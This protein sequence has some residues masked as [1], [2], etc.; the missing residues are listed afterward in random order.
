MLA[1]GDES[2]PPL[3]VRMADP[4]SKYVKALALFRKRILYVNIAKDF[5]VPFSTAAML[6]YN[7]YQCGE[8]DLKA[9]PDYP[10]VV[11]EIDPTEAHTEGKSDSEEEDEEKEEREK[12]KEEKEENEE[13]KEEGLKIDLQTAEVHMGRGKLMSSLAQGHV[14]DQWYG[15]DEKGPFLKQML[16]GLNSIAWYIFLFFRCYCV[17][18]IV[19]LTNCLSSFK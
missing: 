13:E 17:F 4:A 18:V 16:V 1:D 15:K 14:Q 12:E 7:P 9:L 6:P 5:Q 11:D 8:R 3:L 19:S 10:H 2:T